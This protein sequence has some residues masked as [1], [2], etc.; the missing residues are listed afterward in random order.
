MT[1]REEVLVAL[2]DLIAVSTSAK[3]ARNEVLPERVPASGF[4]IL[5]D[6]DPGEPDAILSPLVWLWQHRAMLEV[7]T[8]GHTAAER[9]SRMDIIFTAMGTAIAADRTLGGRCDWVQPHAPAIEEIA[10][11]G[12]A[13]IRA[14]IVPIVLTYGSSDPLA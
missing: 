14:A 5:R 3:A 10:D 1:T 8:V 11:D 4:V 9:T 12:T 6:G 7:F 13:P 2:F